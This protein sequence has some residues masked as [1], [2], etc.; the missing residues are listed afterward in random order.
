MRL[1]LAIGA[2]LL[3]MSLASGGPAQARHGWGSYNLMYV[4]VVEGEVV[5]VHFDKPHVTV[6]VLDGIK[7]WHVVLAPPA[8]MESRGLF[9]DELV[10]GTTLQASGYRS[11]MLDSELRAARIKINDRIVMAR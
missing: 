11:K 10:I 1:A 8:R 2:A 7:V 3:L 6:D 5:A 9:A 4:V